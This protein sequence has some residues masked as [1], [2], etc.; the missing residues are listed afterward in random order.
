MVGLGLRVHGAQ[1][2][3]G[4]QGGQCRS[5]I[6]TFLCVSRTCCVA[7]RSGHIFYTFQSWQGAL[8][9]YFQRVEGQVKGTLSPTLRQFAR[10][11]ESGAFTF[12]FP[13]GRELDGIR[14]AWPS[15]NPISWVI[16]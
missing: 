2:V 14:R 16:N 4:P 3:Q 13:R 8:A 6:Y 7:T 11:F 12:K 10:N 1:G 5:L 15:G 9:W